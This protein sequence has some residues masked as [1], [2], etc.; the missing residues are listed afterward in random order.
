ME[1]LAIAVA[2]IALQILALSPRCANAQ[3]NSILDRVRE[4]TS[5]RAASQTE[6]RANQEVDET[7]DKSVDCMFN[8]IECAKKVKPETAPGA[9]EV[10]AAPPADTTQWYAE[11][12]GARVGP[13][14]REQLATLVTSG[15]VTPS[16]LVWREGM[17]QWTQA[18][19][20][21]ELGDLLKSV[22]PPLPPRSGP[23]PLPTR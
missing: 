1:R 5:S 7:V 15:Q 17:S 12:D 23:P 4:R 3:S 16:T 13:M 14:P 8:P 19:A 11:K 20:V 10:G 21:P 9:G 6:N 2:I 22:P 18:S